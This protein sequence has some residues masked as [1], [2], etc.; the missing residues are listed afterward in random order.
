MIYLTFDCQL[1]GILCGSSE[2]Q[3]R[4]G[5][6]TVGP[7]QLGRARTLSISVSWDSTSD[8]RFVTPTSGCCVLN[9][10]K[11][12]IRGQEADARQ[13][14]RAIREGAVMVVAAFNWSGARVRAQSAS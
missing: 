4:H 10:S 2:L 9:Y 5:C 12:G 1:A 3:R 7:I 11:G 6:E 14:W 8:G 13:G